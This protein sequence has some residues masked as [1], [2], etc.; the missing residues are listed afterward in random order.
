LKKINL[1]KDFVIKEF[2]SGRSRFDIAEELGVSAP[3][4][5]KKL[6]EWG[7]N[8]KRNRFVDK[9]AVVKMYLDGHSE[10]AVSKYFGISRIAVRPIL[11]EAGVRIRNQS[12]AESLKWSKMTKKQRENQV[13]SAHRSVKGRT[14][15]FE[16]RCKIALAIE[17]EQLQISKY[18]IQ[19]ADKLKEKGITPQHQKAIGPYNADLVVGSIVIEIFGGNW[20]WTGHHLERTEE[21]IRFL[22][23]EGFDVLIIPASNV[24][25]LTSSTASYVYNYIQKSIATP[26]KDKEYRVVWKD[27]EYEVSGTIK[28][29]HID[30][31]SPFTS[32]RDPLSGQFKTVLKKEFK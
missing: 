12:E 17:R 9:E 7:V 19:L 31:S 10:N 27:G 6:K 5:Y 23:N 3:L 30:I 32:I 29:K 25:P 18:E 11:T 16:Q 20:H 8:T 1:D 15:T 4:I 24:S 13:R 21:R 28:D 2:E 22:L 14:V 26:R